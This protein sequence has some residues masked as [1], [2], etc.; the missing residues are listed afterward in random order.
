[1]CHVGRDLLLVW[2]WVVSISRFVR[3][4]KTLNPFIYYATCSL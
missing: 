4:K 3:F 2:A 1:L